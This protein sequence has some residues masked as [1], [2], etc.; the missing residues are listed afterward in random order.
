M[1]NLLSNSLE[2]LLKSLPQHAMFIHNFL[3]TP[4]QIATWVFLFLLQLLYKS[5]LKL[6]IIYTQTFQR[7]SS[8]YQ[9]HATTC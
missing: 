6:Y 1:F 8:H 4:V 7:K 5:I 3:N 2:C 9:L